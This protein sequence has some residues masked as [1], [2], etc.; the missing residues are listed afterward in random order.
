MLRKIVLRLG[1]LLFV[2]VAGF[3]IWA[4][5]TNPLMPSAQAALQ[6]DSSVFVE[7]V[8]NWLVFTPAQSTPQTGLVFYPG[9]RVDYRAYAPYARA[10]AVQGFM[11]VIVKMPLNL[12]VLRP[13]A[14]D[15]LISAN[16]QVQS[17]AVGGHS[18]GGAMAANYA[19]DH[20]GQVRG[21]VLMAP[22]LAL[23]GSGPRALRRLRA[24]CGWQVRE[25]WLIKK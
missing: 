18:L 1:S 17:W 10:V 4:S 13:A 24:L 22:A 3:I 9:G 12:A 8:G 23:Q 15:A 6:S 16:P 25:Q 20:L 11:V 21:L 14:A 7:G 19:V 5:I 2:V